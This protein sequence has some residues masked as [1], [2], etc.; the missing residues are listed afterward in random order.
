MPEYKH[1]RRD[2]TIDPTIFVA[3]DD[4]DAIKTV[5]SWC[6]ISLIGGKLDKEVF[7]RAGGKAI[8]KAKPTMVG[9]SPFAKQEWEQIFPEPDIYVRRK[10]IIGIGDLLYITK[11]ETDDEY[12]LGAIRYD[13]A[14]EQLIIRSGHPSGGTSLFEGLDQIKS[15]QNAIN[16]LCKEM[17]I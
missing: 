12:S 1:E 2:Q 16:Q 8:F 14:S 13:P 10:K 15:L 7:S 5:A 9:A 6:N 11:K 3:I 17:G 4:D